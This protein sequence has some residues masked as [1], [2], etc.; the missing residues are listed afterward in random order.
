MSIVAKVVGDHGG[1]VFGRR[2]IRRRDFD[3]TRIVGYERHDRE[4][5]LLEEIYNRHCEGEP[6]GEIHADFQRRKERRAD[7]GAWTCDAV[8]KGFAFVERKREQGE[9]I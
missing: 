4:C 8:R 7:G 9:A 6:L 1:S 3:R 5:R 2:R